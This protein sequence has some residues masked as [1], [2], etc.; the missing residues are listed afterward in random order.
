MV[1]IDDWAWRKGQRYGTL[2]CD[3]E[4]RQIIDLLPDR[5]P[6]T[7]EAWLRERPSIEIVARDRNGGY[8]GAVARALPDAVQVA[9]RWH[10]LENASAAFLTAVRQS[11]PA[12]R[13]AIGAKSLDLKLLTAAEK[14]QFEGF[15]RRQQTNRMV[16]RMAGD[17]VPIKR[18]VRLTGLSRGLIRQIVRGE[19]ED[20]FA[21]VRAA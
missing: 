8:G 7:V 20:V 5:A 10:L 12:I 1:G 14:L 11:M 21:S 17:G 6:A 9:D 18:I 4:R 19:R 13:K 15:Q 3:L 2:I 16:R